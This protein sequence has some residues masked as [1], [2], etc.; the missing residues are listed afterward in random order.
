MNKTH[1]VLDLVYTVDEGQE[2]F[3][4][5][6][7]E[8]N[9]FVSDQTVL[10]GKYS[11]CSTYK[12]VPMTVEESKIHNNKQ[13][14]MMSNNTQDLCTHFDE[15]KID[16]N[17]KNTQHLMTMY[18]RLKDLHSMFWSFATAEGL[19]TMRSNLFT[20]QKEIGEELR[21]RNIRVE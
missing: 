8:C 11:C 13:S 12:V 18:I 14:L 1:I 6:L 16:W 7:E 10:C 2:C 20:I 19:D 5:T 4:G 9:N 17:G 15:T 3:A 21:C